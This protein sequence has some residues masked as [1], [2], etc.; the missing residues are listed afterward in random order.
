MLK[1]NHQQLATQ[2]SIM[3]TIS[4]ALGA[5]IGE[6]L[7]IEAWFEKFGRWLQKSVITKVTRDLLKDLS[8]LP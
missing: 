5:A 3:V 2:G 8:P 4:L 1:I 7:N 6:A